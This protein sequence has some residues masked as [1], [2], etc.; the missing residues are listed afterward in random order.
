MTVFHRCR[1]GH[2]GFVRGAEIFTWVV[3]ENNWQQFQEIVKCFYIRQG[4]CC[5]H[6]KVKKLKVSLANAK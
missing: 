5:V 6:C 1:A 2:R 4:E 3:A